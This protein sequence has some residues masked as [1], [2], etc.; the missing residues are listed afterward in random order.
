MSNIKLI[1]SVQ[2]KP[3]SCNAVHLTRETPACADGGI[4]VMTMKVSQG[5]GFPV[6]ALP[7]VGHMP[8]L[9]ENEEEVALG[10]L[11]G[12]AFGMRLR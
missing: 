3:P 5:R 4:K 9:G 8:E 7:G 2:V 6:V 10:L 11:F 1:V 12:A